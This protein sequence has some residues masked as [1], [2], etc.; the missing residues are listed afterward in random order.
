MSV[1]MPSSLLPANETIRLATLYNSQL[2]SCQDDAELQRLVRL[3]AR[4]LPA[5]HVQLNLVDADYV[6]SLVNQGDVPS[7]QARAECLCAHA[8]LSRDIFYIAD[9]QHHP[10]HFQ[11]PILNSM[12]QLRGYVALPLAAFNG[13]HIGTLCWYS[14]Q[15]WHLNDAD[16]AALRD[17]KAIV[18]H[19]LMHSQLAMLDSTTGL[20]NRRGFESTARLLLASSKRLQQPATLVC[21]DASAMQSNHIELDGYYQHQLYQLANALR[22]CCREADV[23]G[24]IGDTAFGVL[25][26]HSQVAPDLAARLAKYDDGALAQAPLKFAIIAKQ[27]QQ[28]VSFEQMLGSAE[29]QLYAA[30]MAH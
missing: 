15:T 10:V 18:E 26:M 29:R 27:G 28:D 6:F 30:G 24:R 25:L 2:L 20:M 4:L 5:S 19:E 8:I 7:M 16:F 11:H 9:L 22:D 23:I 13:C 1:T 17:F 21:I 14:E 3:A 12:P